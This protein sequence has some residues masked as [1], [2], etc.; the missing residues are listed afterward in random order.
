MMLT[1]SLTYVLACL[2]LVGC[3]A[4]TPSS[5]PPTA[6]TSMTPFQAD[7]AFLNQHTTIVVLT[8]QNGAAQVAV[9]P[10]YQ[11][12]VMTSTTGGNDSPSFGWLG[13]AAIASGQRQP[14][15]NVFGGEDRFWLGP[16]GGQFAL[17][18]KRGDPFDLVHWHVPEPFDWGAWEVS[19]QSASLVQ[20]HKRM[21]LANFSGTPFDI[22]VDRTVRLLSAEDA[23]SMLDTT[24]AESVRMVAFESS[25]TVRNAGSAGWKP[26]S[27]LVSI[28][29]LGQFNP[30]PET[31]IVL[32]IESGAASTLGP[33]V[34]DAYFGKVPGTRLKIT[35]GTIF[36]R[37]DGRY[38]SKIGVSPLRALPLAGSYDSASHVLTLVQ[39]TRP[40]AARDYVNSMW[41]IQREPYRGDVVNS[42]NDG[43]PA[44]G[45]PPLGPFYELETS[46]PALSLAPGEGYTH[47]H[48]TFHFAG[49]DADLDRLARATLKVGLDAITRA[50]SEGPG[51]NGGRTTR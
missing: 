33:P 21:T 47:V 15:M 50:L 48:R 36:F 23:A 6:P 27:G 43:P 4:E 41:A 30:S 1:R 10:G 29:I 44:P 20:F 38:R 12:R 11:G 37:G 39:Y 13:R 24:A 8:G 49:P 25:N 14:H 35:D 31:T 18:F 19:R 42:Y 34:N 22:D 3:K 26:E 51:V 40:A 46:S 17:Y 5:G 45:Q 28:W 9:A 2:A 7:L 32:P 16:E